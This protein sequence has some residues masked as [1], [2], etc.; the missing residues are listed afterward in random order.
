MGNGRILKGKVVSTRM[1]RSILVEVTRSYRHRIYG[2]E[3]HVKKKFMAHDM[4]E[5][6]REGDLVTIELCRPISKRKRHTLIKVQKPISGA[7]PFE[8]E[9]LPPIVRKPKV[10]K[11]VVDLDKEWLPAKFRKMKEASAARLAAEQIVNEVEAE[12]GEQLVDR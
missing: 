6:A 11:D 8:T 1:Q 2:K 10:I 12:K 9:A 3:M 7:E 4:N 5:V